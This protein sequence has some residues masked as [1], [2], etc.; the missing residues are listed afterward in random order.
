MT[1]APDLG[2]LWAEVMLGLKD[3]AQTVEES[4]YTAAKMLTPE[5][6]TIPRY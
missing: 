2:Q 5:K 6:R 4:W 1:A 3:T